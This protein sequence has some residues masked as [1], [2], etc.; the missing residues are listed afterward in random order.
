MCSK[1]HKL[2]LTC[3]KSNPTNKTGKPTRL[4]NLIQSLF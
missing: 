1:L 2:L 3:G 4:R